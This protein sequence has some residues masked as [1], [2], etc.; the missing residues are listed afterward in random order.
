MH[1]LTDVCTRSS[2]T[3]P[4]RRVRACGAASPCLLL[5]PEQPA[6]HLASP[7]GPWLPA[8]GGLALPST[9]PG[10]LPAGTRLGQHLYLTSW[11]Q[12]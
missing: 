8:D 3:L 12:A 7:G 11:T 2:I 9:S 4:S 5:P 6:L 1:E 10:Q